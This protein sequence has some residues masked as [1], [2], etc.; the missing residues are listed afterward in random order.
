MKITIETPAYNK[1]RYGRPWIG[2]ATGE[3][4]GRL[5][6]SFG[7]WIGSPGEAGRLEIEA[8]AGDVIARGQKD[9]RNSRNSRRDAVAYWILEADGTL[10]T[11][12][13]VDAVDAY[14][15]HTAGLTDLLHTAEKITADVGDEV[16]EILREGQRN[17]LPSDEMRGLLK[18][19]IEVMRKGAA[20]RGDI[21]MVEKLDRD[22]EAM[23]ARAIHPP[24]SVAGTT[25]KTAAEAG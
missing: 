21:W 23:I 12:T 3:Q 4:D 7:T 10:K 11:V 17:L 25:N 20:G 14:R 2:R 22:A 13:T 16:R 8:A 24:L 9:Y 5:T 19:S 18:R 1:L 15:R 6:L